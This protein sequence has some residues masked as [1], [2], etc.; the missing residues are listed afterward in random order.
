M[1][2]FSQAQFQHSVS[3]ISNNLL[4][5]S[6]IMKNYIKELRTQKK[7]SQDQLAEMAG[8][9]H[10]Q[11]HY[12][13]SGKR[14]LTQEWVVRLANALEVH[15]L[16]ITDGPASTAAAKDAQEREL[17][18][19]FRGLDD[20]AKSMY[21]HGLRTFTNAAPADKNQINSKRETKEKKSS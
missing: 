20:S 5:V 4:P 2:N 17:L 15:P 11:I 14:K 16:E 19:A 10:Q 13:E 21:L 6:E 9:T 8:T 18:E 1:L 3:V 12:L 7:L